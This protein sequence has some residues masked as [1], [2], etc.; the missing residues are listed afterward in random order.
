MNLLKF[1]AASS[2]V[3]DHLPFFTVLKGGQ[4]AWFLRQA[5]ENMRG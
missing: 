3:K 2:N 1:L 4:E 5:K